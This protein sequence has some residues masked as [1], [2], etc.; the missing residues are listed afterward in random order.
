MLLLFRDEA[1]AREQLAQL[2]QATS[3]CAPVPLPGGGA[4]T[5]VA[6]IPLDHI[7]G[8]AEETYAFAEQ[9]HHD[10]GLVSDLTLVEISRIG[11]ALY[12]DSKY[13]AAGGDGVIADVLSLMERASRVPMTAMCTF[14]ATTCGSSLD[15]PGDLALGTGFEIDPGESVTGPSP[16][17][18]G[19]SFFN[20]CPSQVWPG[21]GATDRLAVRLTAA[22]HE[23]VRD[24]TTYASTQEAA[25]TVAG[26][27]ERC[28]GTGIVQLAADTGYPDSITIG[29]QDG[30]E[31]RLFQV[32]RIGRAVLATE[33]SGTLVSGSL[34]GDEPVFTNDNR[35]ATAVVDEACGDAGC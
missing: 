20:T 16:T 7:A 23:V 29:V 5:L 18:N 35:V 28:R 22:D 10:D 26:I 32:V 3:G 34:D 1:A 27:S 14:S 4:E 6:P 13:G 30:D 31:G 8:P 19:V 11:N 24:L 25:Q 21:A 15:I 9:V 17:I 2:K 33:W 12:V